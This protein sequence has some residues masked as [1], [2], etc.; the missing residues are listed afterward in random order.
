MGADAD[1]LALVGA[2]RSFAQQR[3]DDF[4]WTADPL[5]EHDWQTMMASHIVKA[6]YDDLEPEFRPLMASVRGYTMTSVER[7]Y[8]LY[9]CAEYLARAR[10]AGDLPTMREKTRVK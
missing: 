4:G 3:L 10:I 7:M 9:K 2:A 1:T 8:L 6:G 5:D